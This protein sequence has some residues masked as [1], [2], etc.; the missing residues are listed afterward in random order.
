MS[1]SL[2]NLF[3]PELVFINDNLKTIDEVFSF[4]VSQLK[5]QGIIQSIKEEELKELFLTRE[6]LSSTGIGNGIALPHILVPELKEPIG[7]VIR[8]K[9]G[10]EWEAI[11]GQPVRLVVV[12]LSPPTMRDIYLKYLGEIAGNL[13][14]PEVLKKII[15]AQK[16]REIY[17]LITEGITVSF[18]SRYAQLFYFVLGILFFLGF[19][20]F[21]F[22]RL[23]LPNIEL[24][25]RLGYLRFNEPIWIQRE[26]LSTVLFFSMV[27]GTLLFFRY[28]VAFACGALSILLLTGVLDIRTTIEFMSIPTILFIISVMIL[29]KWFE[30]KGLFKYFVIKVLKNFFTS[31]LV[32]YG[33]LMFLSAILAGFVDEVSAILI[34]FGIALEI[35]RYIKLNITA[36]LLGLVM[37]TN[38]GSALTLIGNPI[39]IYVA[40]AGNL[41]FFDFLRNAT[42]VALLS[43][44][45]VI[46]IVLGIHRSEFQLQKSIPHEE[47]EKSLENLDRRELLLAALVFI[48]F[49]GAVISHSFI[50]K[51]LKV[52]DKTTL[53]ASVLILVGF[54]V[55]YEEESGRYFIEKGPDWWTILYFMFL[56]ANAACLEYT[57]V[58]AKIAYF[59]SKLAQHLPLDFL[60]PAKES[61]GIATLLLWGSAGLS[62]FVDNLPIVAALVPVVRDLGTQGINGAQLF[63]WALLLG[64]C[65]GGNLTMIGS[66]ANLVAIGMYE[67]TARKKF[68]F[69]EWLKLGIVVFFVSL[70][71]A[72]IFLLI[73]LLIRS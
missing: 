69:R 5:A 56:F 16:A 33:V 1:L 26:I 41:T 27:L 21:L 54:I 6:A 12:L 2:K 65:F 58:T 22:H 47:F 72:N 30:N 51:L 13:E 11:D 50:E 34:T 29:V 49:V 38:L 66:T 64:G 18:F 53:L 63:W 57:G 23:N 52:E 62:G 70:V 37:A 35:N 10:I 20:I 4:V 32:L 60:G 17:Q 3:R 14:N 48:I 71:I 8:V 25:S 43:V 15:R 39:G 67:K 44:V 31:P 19:S 42:L 24:Y 7:V 45:V 73:N 61:V 9:S 40:F 46:L 36:L 55:L 28:R 68:S 59:L